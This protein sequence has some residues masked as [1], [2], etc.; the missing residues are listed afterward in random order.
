MLYQQRV[1][2]EVAKHLPIVGRCFVRVTPSAVQRHALQVILNRALRG[3]L[4][5]NELEFFHG[6][7]L[8]LSVTDLFFE[9]GISLYGDKLTVTSPKTR[10]DVKLAASSRDLLL[11]AAQEVDVDRLF[12]QRRLHMSGDTQLGL[13]IKNL[14]ASQE[15]SEVVPAHLL[16][17]LRKLT[18]AIT[19]AGNE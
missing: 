2:Q 7:I 15:L 8:N 12:F 19:L 6:K 14:L 4:E 5:R 13:G 17:P 9:V 1:I 10:A 3:P 11:I 18:A 16:K